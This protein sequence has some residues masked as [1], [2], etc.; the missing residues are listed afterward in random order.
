MNTT[1][2]RVLVL[3][4]LGFVALALVWPHLQNSAVS[5]GKTE[6]LG[7]TTGTLTAFYFHGNF[8]CTT[9]LAIEALT[10]QT[11][12]DS[13]SLELASHELQFVSR[14]TDKEAHAHFVS[15]FSLSNGG[16]VLARRD[17]KGNWV[18]RCLDDV[19]NLVN[20]EAAFRAYLWTETQDM[21]KGADS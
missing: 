16:V 21:L 5:K 10:Q 6:A 13:F 7:D 11:L 9:C 14:N 1:I 17:T 15:D 18:Y 19:W 4:L 8:R 12:A 20:D 2:R 3:L